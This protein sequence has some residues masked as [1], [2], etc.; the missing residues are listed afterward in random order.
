M[1][2]DPEKQNA[3]KD[4]NGQDTIQRI[5]VGVVGL[6]A[7]LL[8]VSVANF[9]LQRAS[10]E[11]SAIQEIQTEALENAG[12]IAAEAEPT[13]VPVQAPAEPLAEMGITPAPVQ[14]E[15]VVEPVP[16]VPG[17]R[18]QVVPDLEPDPKLEAPMDKEQ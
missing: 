13:P 14:E 18:A 8:V 6:V 7:V 10:D 5:Q 15:E 17:T 4:N 9:V 3:K 11:Q 1:I 16:I 12:R 2:E